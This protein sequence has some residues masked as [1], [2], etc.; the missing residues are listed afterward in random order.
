M[1]EGS[2]LSTAKGQEGQDLLGLVGTEAAKVQVRIPMI[3]G[4]GAGKEEEKNNGVDGKA[5]EIGKDG[6][7][8]HGKPQRPHSLK[9]SRKLL[10]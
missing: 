6:A 5:G 2:R 7:T 10:P 8:S 3:H 1:G 9:A 4:P